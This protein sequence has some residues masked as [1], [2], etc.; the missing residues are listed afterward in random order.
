MD[1]A[2]SKI[3]PQNLTQCCGECTL[4]SPQQCVGRGCMTNS[5][6][7][8]SNRQNTAIPNTMTASLCGSHKDLISD[9][10]APQSTKIPFS[11]STSFPLSTFCH[12]PSIPLLTVATSLLTISPYL[13]AVPSIP[14]L[15]QFPVTLSY[16]LPH[17]I[18]PPFTP[19]LLSHPLPSSG[20]VASLRPS[21]KTH[22]RTSSVFVII[23]SPLLPHFFHTLLF[24]PFN[25][26]TP[27]CYTPPRPLQHTPTPP[28]SNPCTPLPRAYCTVPR[29]QTRNK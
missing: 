25:E 6:T 2:N 26:S 14:Y 19:S 16:P 29:L 24:A 23:T 1:S 15:F 7:R 18:L 11:P 21:H 8:A 27:P 13:P 4:Y 20:S 28:L 10:H 17:P 3:E 22:I 5:G 12:I 9:L